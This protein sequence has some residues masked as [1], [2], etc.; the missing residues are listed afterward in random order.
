MT[1]PVLQFT[2]I[3][4]TYRRPARLSA[5]LASLE[6]LEYP[7]DRLEIVVAVDER[8]GPSLTTEHE[9]LARRMPL[10]FLRLDHGGPAAARNAAAH[11][12]RGQFLAFTDDDCA[13]SPDWLLRL[14]EPLSDGA[15]VVGGRTVN[16]LADNL[17]SEASQTLVEH[18]YRYCNAD[19][20]DSRFF[21]SNNL[22]VE[23]ALFRQLDGF[24]ESFGLAGGEDRDLCD[25]LLAA[26]VR[27]VYQPQ[28]VVRHF[29]TL[30]AGSFWKQHFRYGQSAFQFRKARARRNAGPVRV[31]P[32]RFYAELLRSPFRDHRGRTALTLAALLGVSQAANAAGFF[33]EAWRRRLDGS[34]LRGHPEAQP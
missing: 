7:R 18:V 13:P 15:R 33:R 31:E 8:E 27:L 3:V 34:A 28:A 14:E 26:G 29:H 30:S 9:A 1:S 17:F 25:R 5:C 2:V 19:P 21:A 24:D 10:K 32:P 16:A 11:V 6:A 22:A 4:P 23:T 20:R 12:A